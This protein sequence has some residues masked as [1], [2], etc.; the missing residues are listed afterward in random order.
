MKA[1]A[2]AML[3]C[4]AASSQASLVSVGAI[5]ATGT[6]FGSVDTV[7]TL[8]SE[9]KTGVSGG[10]VS[11]D[12]VND[13]TSGTVQPGA[14]HNATYSFG[15]L[16]VTNASELLFIFNA[17]EPAG[18]SIRLD[19]LILSIFS[20]TGQVL[21]TLGLAA[22]VNFAATDTGGGK[23]G[24]GFALDVPD[25]MLAQ[26]FIS[27]T[28]RIGLEASVSSATGASD[29][30]YVVALEG[31]GPGNE[32]PEPGSVALLGLGLAGVWAAR[33]ARSKA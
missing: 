1:V 31:E 5:P 11:W 18:N 2:A 13:Q 16:N 30:F 15:E 19:S 22:P 33:R 32:I 12:G 9:N 7:L 14:V 29:T 17:A 25:Y 28:N 8:S 20:S 4:A 23:S 27:A 6:G 26:P 3:L 10:S 21:Y 24:Y